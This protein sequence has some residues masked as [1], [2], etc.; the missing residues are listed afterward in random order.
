MPMRLVTHADG[1]VAVL[2][3]SD[4]PLSRRPCQSAELDSVVTLH[5]LLSVRAFL[6]FHRLGFSVLERMFSV[7]RT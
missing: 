4:W 2:C 5:V 3:Q 6:N 1:T 7:E